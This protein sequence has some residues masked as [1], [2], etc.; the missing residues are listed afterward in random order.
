[1]SH[2]YV[3]FDLETTGLDP[4]KNRIIEVGAVKV[5]EGRVIARY[6]RIINPH[7]TLEPR[8]VELTNITQEMVEAG[9]EEKDVV[10]EF[11]QFC[12]EYPLLGHNVMFDYKF[13]KTATYRHGI[14][15]EKQGNDT[16]SIARKLLK[17]LPKRNLDALCAHYGYKNEHAHRAYHDALATHYI[18]EAMSKEFEKDHKELF[19]FQPLSYK[20]KKQEPMTIKQKRYLNDLIKYHKIKDENLKKELS[21]S[22]A[23]KA[24]DAI[25]LQYGKIPYQRT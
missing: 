20:V 6:N 8:I 15:F 16:L 12:E 13:M 4:V 19:C 1:M 25:I 18:Y 3:V 11:V 17:D 2:S 24:I 7:C 22:E 9:L 5:K 23:S 21:K 10:K 14:S